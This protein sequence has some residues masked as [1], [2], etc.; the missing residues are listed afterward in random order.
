MNKTDLQLLLDYTLW[1]N[2]KLLEAATKLKPEQFAAPHRTTYGSLRGILLHMLGSMMIWRNRCLAGQWVTLPRPEDFPDLALLTAR[3]E[4][5]QAA[6]RQYIETQSDADLQRSIP[7]TTSKGLAYS[8]IQWMIFAHV[9]NHATQHRS[10]AAELL[11]EWG[12]SP[13]D[14]DLIVYLRQ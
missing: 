2:R 4:Q 10:E 9:C 5:E 13:G 12:C 1:A 14:L 3:L 6:L 8:D 11:T 7:Y